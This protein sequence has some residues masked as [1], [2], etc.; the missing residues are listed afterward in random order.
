LNQK[1]FFNQKTL[2]LRMIAVILAAGYGTR[3]YPL[4]KNKAKALLPLG[5]STILDKILDKVSEIPLSKIIIVSNNRFFN[6]FLE[7]KKSSPFK[8]KISLINDG[9]NTPE[10]ALGWTKDLALALPQIN[11][12]FLV[13]ASDTLFGFKMSDFVSKF[14]GSP[15][16][17]V[18][19]VHSIESAKKYG[20]VELSGDKIL[21]FEEKPPAPK[22]TK[23]ACL[24]YLFPIKVKPMINEM[25]SSENKKHLI[26]YLFSKLSLKAFFFSNYMY[27]IGSI[28]G[29]EE[30]KEKGI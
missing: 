9:T 20:V 24:F 16:L 28:E 30:V 19:D 13:L 23:K 26:E 5:S 8:E 21:S 22:S 17:A 27:D 2:F 3:M 15:L 7:W 6:D 4:T 12:D 10:T 29:Y 14:S 1:A 11:E 25:I 18:C